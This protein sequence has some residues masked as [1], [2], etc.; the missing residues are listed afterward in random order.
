MRTAITGGVVLACALAGCGPMRTG[1]EF[2]ILRPPCIMQ[3]A[4]LNQGNASIDVAT[5]DALR[6]ALRDRLRLERG[7]LSLPPLTVPARPR[8]EAESFGLAPPAA[9]PCPQLGAALFELSERLRGVEQRLSIL[10]GPPRKCAA[11]ERVPPPR[12]DRD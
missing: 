9:A 8:C 12:A 1:F 5:V 11:P 6:E 4:V 10:A 3:S 7:E 2:K